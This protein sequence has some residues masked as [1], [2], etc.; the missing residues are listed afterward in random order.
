M[1][2]KFLSDDILLETLQGDLLPPEELVDAI[3]TEAKNQFL[4]RLEDSLIKEKQQYTEQHNDVK[5]IH[6]FN[7]LIEQA[8]ELKPDTSPTDK[9]IIQTPYLDQWLSNETSRTYLPE[10]ET[11]FFKK[12]IVVHFNNDDKS[13]KLNINLNEHI[14]PNDTINEDIIE[15]KLNDIKESIIPKLSEY[16]GN[17]ALSKI[18]TEPTL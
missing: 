6:N 10:E 13:K 12:H 15:D 8:L 17:L 16:L 3:Y 18:I 4:S 9:A 11:N 14:S 5:I 7:K 1:F 2:S